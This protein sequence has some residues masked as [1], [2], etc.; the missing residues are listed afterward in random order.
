MPLHFTSNP[1]VVGAFL[2]NEISGLGKG[3]NRGSSTNL[4]IMLLTEYIIPDGT[5]TH[6]HHGSE[7]EVPVVRAS[8]MGCFSLPTLKSREQ[9]S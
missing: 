6:Q 3:V 9:E 1:P 7:A 4:T 2:L 5:S 8:R